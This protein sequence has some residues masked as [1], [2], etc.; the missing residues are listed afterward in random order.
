MLTVNKSALTL[1]PHTVKLAS[2]VMARVYVYVLRYANDG[3][4]LYNRYHYFM[5]ESS[6]VSIVQLWNLLSMLL[7]A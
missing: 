7:F 3:Y 2:T 6:E 4:E 1:R 5:L